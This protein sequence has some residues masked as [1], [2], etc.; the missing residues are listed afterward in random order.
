MMQRTKL[1]P[2]PT[3]LQRKTCNYIPP[4]LF[5][6]VGQ[7]R[8]SSYLQQWAGT[9]S[10]RVNRYGVWQRGSG[11]FPVIRSNTRQSG[12]ALPSS[13]PSR[14]QAQSR[15]VHRWKNN[16]SWLLGRFAQKCWAISIK[17]SA[18]H[19]R[20]GNLAGGAEGEWHRKGNLKNFP[21]PAAEQNQKQ[22]R[23]SQ[24]KETEKGWTDLVWL[25]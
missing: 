22:C 21:S 3:A 24:R 14:L 4:Q 7:L 25:V 20:E 8:P 11:N 19:P 13:V 10:C 12:G 16:L 6:Q 5:D 23:G 1:I 18:S 15:C 17:L 9:S 2:Y